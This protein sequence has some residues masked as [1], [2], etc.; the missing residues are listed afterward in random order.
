[1]MKHRYII[2]KKLKMTDLPKTTK[3]LILIGD[4]IEELKRLPSNCVDVIITSPPYFGQRDYKT[5]GQIGQEKEVEDYIK[6]MVE[7]GNELKRVLRD[8]GSY[9][10]NI[11][12]YIL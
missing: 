2:K 11:G 4:V 6:K 10:L 9:F 7:V 12:D 5:E 1:M 8:S 3:P